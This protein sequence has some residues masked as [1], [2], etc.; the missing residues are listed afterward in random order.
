MMSERPDSDYARG[1]D[2]PRRRRYSVWTLLAPVAVVV[3]WVSLFVSLGDAS[4][5]GSDD[6]SKESAAKT[7]KTG[8]ANDLKKGARMKV[9]KGDTLQAIASRVHLTEDE[10]KACNP[11]IDPQ[12]LQPGQFIAVAAVD[13]EGADR[14]AVGANPDPLAGETSAAAGS[15]SATGAAGDTTKNGTAAADPSVGA[16]HDSADDSSSGD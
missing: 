4:I 1:T 6:S 7:T 13:C 14:A 5:F 2:I 10:L 12:T 8:P 11:A 3:L 15:S 16:Q 9:H